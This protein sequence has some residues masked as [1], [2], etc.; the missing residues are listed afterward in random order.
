[1][2]DELTTINCGE[3]KQDVLAIHR[4]PD[5][6]GGS[7][8]HPRLVVYDLSGFSSPASPEFFVFVVNQFFVE[9]CGDDFLRFGSGQYAWR[10]DSPPL[11]VGMP[12]PLF[13][14]RG[15]ESTRQAYCPLP[16]LRKST[17]QRSTKNW[18]TTKTKNSGEAGL[19]Y[20]FVDLLCLQV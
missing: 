17:P 10:V 5:S 7:L 6:A 19:W 18:F 13:G 11:A 4:L 3:Y 8:L 12:L 15:G 16:N 1:M 2:S 20:I 9:R 14:L